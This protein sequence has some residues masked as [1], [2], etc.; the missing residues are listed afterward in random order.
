MTTVL[1]LTGG[2]GSGKSTVSRLLADRGAVV[3]DAD[4]IVHELQRAGEPVFEAIV[5]HFGDEVVGPD[6]ELD[7]PALG[8][9]VFDDAEARARLGRL[10]HGPVGL[11]MA[12]RLE[13][14][15]STEAALI[16][17]DIPLLFE[18]RPVGSDAARN[19]PYDS[20]ALVWVP[21]AVQVERTVARDA[22]SVEDANR[23][24]DA[25]LP[26]DDKREWADFVIDNSG[27]L[28]HTAQQV[29]RL[30]EALA[31]S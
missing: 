10:T 23:R 6:G 14:A 5:E 19:A 15:R 1:G 9:L 24:I 7:R 21:A 4:A 20:T 11:E 27:S 28:E 18:G 17:L 22:C 12:R 3:I 13:A 29:D 8:T 26:L 2:I 31:R 30:V 16:V 25:Q